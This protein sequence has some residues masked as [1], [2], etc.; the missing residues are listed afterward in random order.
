MLCHIPAGWINVGWD[1]FEMEILKRWEDN[2]FIKPT[3][4]EPTKAQVPVDVINQE[5][6]CPSAIRDRQIEIQNLL[7][8]LPEIKNLLDTLPE[9]DECD[10]CGD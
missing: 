8:K 5:F 4:V 9:C 6:T 2:G 7:D 1:E 10:N 3:P